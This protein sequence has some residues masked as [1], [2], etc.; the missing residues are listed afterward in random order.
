MAE[1]GCYVGRALTLVGIGSVA[2]DLGRVGN[3]S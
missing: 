1:I 3:M 2:A